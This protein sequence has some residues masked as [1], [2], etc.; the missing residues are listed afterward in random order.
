[1]QHHGS[2][3]FFNNGPLEPVGWCL[4]VKNPLFHHMV[5]LNIKLKGMANAAV[6]KQI[7]CPYKHPRPPG[8]GQRS[9]Q[10]V[11][12]LHMQLMGMDHR[13]QCKHTVVLSHT[14]GW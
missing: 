4:K 13:A 1:M 11:V 12:M 14:L 2:I 8:W 6:C 10:N 3:Y 9:K 5:M 7:F